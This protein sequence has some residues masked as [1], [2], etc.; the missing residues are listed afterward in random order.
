MWPTRIGKDRAAGK[1]TFLIAWIAQWCETVLSE[2]DRFAV[3]KGP[4]LPIKTPMTSIITSR[5]PKVLVMDFTVLELASDGGENVLVLTDIF[6][7]SKDPGQVEVQGLQSHQSPWPCL[8]NWASQWLRTHQKLLS[9]PLICKPIPN[10]SHGYHHDFRQELTDVP[11]E[12]TEPHLKEVLAT[13]QM[14]LMI[15]SLLSKPLRTPFEFQLQ[16][17]KDKPGVIL[18][19][20]TRD[21]MQ[22]PIIS[23][24]Y[25]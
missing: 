11:Q 17:Q 2:C 6:K 5:P 7:E 25:Q 8:W 14:T 4:Y 20:L 19:C 16:S 15:S 22:T 13:L 23:P 1:W 9:I 21:N 10:A 3:A 12:L 24:E 18:P